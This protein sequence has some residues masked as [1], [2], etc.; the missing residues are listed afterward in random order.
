[1]RPPASVGAA[2]VNTSGYG[3]REFDL[4]IARADRTL[5]NRK[6]TPR[7]TA[8]S[9]PTAATTTCALAPGAAH[10]G[11]RREMGPVMLGRPAMIELDPAARP[12][13]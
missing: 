8:R 12:F 10:R 11:P 6:G 1:M 13:P 5:D 2:A 4:E 7:V 3:K 9:V